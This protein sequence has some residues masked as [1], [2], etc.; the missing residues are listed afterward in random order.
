MASL[1]DLRKSHIHL[2]VSIEFQE[3]VPTKSVYPCIIFLFFLLV[4]L[5][6]SY[7]Y[8]TQHP[9]SPGLL[10]VH[11]ASPLLALWSNQEP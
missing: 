10:L 9:G 4:K 11:Q 5:N 3:A 6:G 7:K 1:V 2:K 8:E